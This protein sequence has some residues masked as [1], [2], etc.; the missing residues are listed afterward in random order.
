MKKTGFVLVLLL[1]CGSIFSLMRFDGSNIFS[2]TDI[3]TFNKHLTGYGGSDVFSITTNSLFNKHLT[4]YDGSDVFSITSNSLFNKH[5]TG[6]AVS[7]ECSII[8]ETLPV[9]V[10]SFMVAQAGINNVRLQWVTQSE[11]NVYGFHIYK[12]V[13]P[14]LMQAQMLDILINGT[15][16]SQMQIYVYTDEE[17]YEPG[18]YYYWLEVMDINLSSRFFG[19]RSVTVVYP[20]GD[21]EIPLVTKILSIFPNP[22][23]PGTWISYS[24]AEKGSVKLEIFNLKGQLVKKLVIDNKTAGLYKYYW[25]GRNQD[26]INCT[27]GLYLLRFSTQTTFQTAKLMLIK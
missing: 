23:N 13:Q 18:T 10:T 5:L 16:T 27:S 4:G 22:F 11:S 14:E 20:T 25:D 3:I 1:L 8:E 26:G 7:G 21:Q 15:N 12:S 9:E 17:I 19:P 6:Y 2:T 24:I